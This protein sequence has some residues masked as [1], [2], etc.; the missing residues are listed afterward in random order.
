M[1]ITVVVRY[2]GSEKTRLTFDGTQRVVIGRGP[3]SD[4]RL[5]DTSVSY[6]HATLRAQ[7]AEFVLVDEGSTN[8]TFVGE[9]RIAPNTSRL[10]RSG[11]SVRVGR[12]SLELRMD[13]S[14]ITRDLAV[15]TRDLALALVAEA[16]EAAGTDATTRVRVVEGVDQGS[17][18]ALA[19]FEHEYV[20]GRASHC[21]LQLTDPDV[22]REHIRVARR[23]EGVVVVDA[24][25]KNG[26]SVGAVRVGPREP[27][28]WRPAQMIGIGRTV[29]SLEEPLND[30]LA[31]IEGSPDERL[32]LA[33]GGAVA[34]PSGGRVG[35]PS[36]G[37]S[38]GHGLPSTPEAAA[39][40]VEL[41]A[42]NARDS[43]PVPSV[44]VDGEVAPVAT[45]S[46]AAGAGALA[47]RRPSG[48]PVA[49][50]S[51]RGGRRPRWSAADVVVMSAAIGVLAVSLAGLVWLLRG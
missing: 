2:A 46:E 16:I 28:V 18:L 19:Q 20:I 39:T 42:A 29:L 24:G 12:M 14:P 32:A 41:P 48:A 30:A 50:P 44:P 34:D 38:H 23:S 13:R 7:G 49:G 3:G 40:G 51:R 17:M 11:D 4:V 37:H 43:P 25:A 21:D 1:G 36:H 6:R 8:G 35:S 5:P 27:A 15:A 26:T 31:R 22:S 33:E 45:E 47:A 9:I 10:V